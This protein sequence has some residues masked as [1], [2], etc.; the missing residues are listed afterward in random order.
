MFKF[1]SKQRFFTLVLAYCFYRLKFK[2]NFLSL[3][4]RNRLFPFLLDQVVLFLGSTIPNK[5]RR[6]EF[7]LKF[8][9]EKQY[10]ITHAKKR[11]FDSILNRTSKFEDML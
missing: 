7:C 3:T 8:S 6:Q 11:C 2:R 10:A 4:I 1:L 9:R 5:I